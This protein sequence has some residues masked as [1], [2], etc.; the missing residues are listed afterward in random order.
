MKDEQIDEF[1]GQGGS[2]VRDP[3][4]GKRTRVHLTRSPE[5]EQVPQPAAAAEPA[6]ATEKE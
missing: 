6:K 1:H 5:P 4:T 3:K 2:Y